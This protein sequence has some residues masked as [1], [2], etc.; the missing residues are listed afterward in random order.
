MLRAC[1]LNQC[2]RSLPYMVSVVFVADR[3]A[4]AHGSAPPTRLRPLVSTMA[5]SAGSPRRIPDFVSEAMASDWRNLRSSAVPSITSTV[6]R[7]AICRR[8]TWNGRLADSVPWRAR[9]SKRLGRLLDGFSVWDQEIMGPENEQ[10][11]EIGGHEIDRPTNLWDE[12]I[13]HPFMRG[14]RP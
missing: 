1:Y 5:A 11:P 14:V 12:E 4:A 9:Q 2:C 13:E 3:K 8:E 7:N 10:S 6:G